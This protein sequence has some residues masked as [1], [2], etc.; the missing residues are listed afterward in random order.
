MTNSDNPINIDL[1]KGDIIGMADN[2]N[3]QKGTHDQQ[4]YRPWLV[5][6]AGR[7]YSNTG[8]AILIPFTKAP[9]KFPTNI[10]WDQL[11]T[12]SVTFGTLLVEQCKSLDLSNREFDYVERVTVP[13]EVDE[14]LRIILDL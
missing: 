9:A 4:G 6:A 14:M 11:N 12:G 10:D 5:M 13:K 3:T 1:E 7:M 8:F 2:E